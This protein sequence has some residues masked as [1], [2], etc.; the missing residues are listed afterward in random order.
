M[1]K[2]FSAFMKTATSITAASWI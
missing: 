1:G 2:K